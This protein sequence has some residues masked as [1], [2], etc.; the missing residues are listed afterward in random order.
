MNIIVQLTR[1]DA[2]LL[3]LGVK[4]VLHLDRP[5]LPSGRR[6]YYY[7][8]PDPVDS[9]L[10]APMEWL[11]EF[12]NHRWYGNINEV[13]IIS[14]GALWGFFDIITPVSSNMNVWAAGVEEPRYLVDNIHLFYD[15][16]TAPIDDLRTAQGLD[17]RPSY[18]LQ[19]V[20]PSFHYGQGTLSLPV[21][22]LSFDVLKEVGTILLDLTGTISSIYNSWKDDIDVVTIFSGIRR[23]NYCFQ[24]E[25]IKEMVPGTDTPAEYPSLLS[26]TGKACREMLAICL[27]YPSL[28]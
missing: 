4:N 12:E 24:A 2:Q 17:E 5:D 22:Q 27:H 15:P 20:Q 10:T 26:P 28:D 6:C 14:S 23:R 11:Q 1:F 19:P 13:C 21:R 8:V 9:I 18:V 3:A 25:V 7:V 16:I